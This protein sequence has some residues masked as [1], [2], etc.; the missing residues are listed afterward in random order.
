MPELFMHD[1]SSHQM[2]SI[3]GSNTTIAPTEQELSSGQENVEKG[4]N[5][6]KIMTGVNF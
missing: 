6:K 1:T 2:F 3:G 5:S 4:N